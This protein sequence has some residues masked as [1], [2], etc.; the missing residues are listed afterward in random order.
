MKFPLPPLWA[1]VVLALG[2]LLAAWNLLRSSGA[3]SHVNG[4]TAES[5]AQPWTTTEENY[6]L[7][8]TVELFNISM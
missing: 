6:A 3:G 1:F 2:A 5:S 8:R 7:N 4:W